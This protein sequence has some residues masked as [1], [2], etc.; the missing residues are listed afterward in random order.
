MRFQMIVDEESEE[1]VIATVHTPSTLT[2]KIEMLVLEYTGK[3]TV[4]GFTENGF[5]SLSFSMI[6]CVFVERGKTFAVLHDGSRYRLDLR[7]YEI[8]QR[9]PQSFLRINKSAIGNIHCV[10]SFQST[11]SG[12]VDAHFLCGH[13]EYVSRRC[14]SSIKRSLSL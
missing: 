1:S 9:L 14:L 3:D 13:V 10:K 5:T 12:A 11:L 7:L 8:E 4:I 6:E 2:D